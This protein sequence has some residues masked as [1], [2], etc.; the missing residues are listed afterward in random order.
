[1]LAAAPD[2]RAD[3]DPASDVLPQQDVYYGV[4]LD[5]K[6]KPAAQLPALLAQAREKGYPIKV[7]LIADLADLGVATFLWKDPQEYARYLGQELALVYK[8]RTLIL[9]PDGY[10]YFRDGRGPGKERRVLARLD[11]PGELGRFL[12]RAIE[13]VRRL[14]AAD[15][16]RLAVPDVTPPADGVP[17][18]QGHNAAPAQ[19][20][21]IKIYNT[22]TP[23]PTARPAGGGSAAW[24]F[25]VPVGLFALAAGV[26]IAISRRRGSTPTTPGR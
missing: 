7:A 4:G 16:V 15:G 5:M 25:L 17:R 1:M 2:A 9:M 18:L 21:K 10:G 12:P 3:G 22:V 8:E 6:S 19:T 24:L 23:A 11:P 13:A 20:P 14:A 26:A